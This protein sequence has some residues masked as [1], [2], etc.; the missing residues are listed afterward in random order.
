MN[1]RLDPAI[2]YKDLPPLRRTGVSYYLGHIT[3]WVKFHT[4]RYTPDDYLND[5][6]DDYLGVE[7]EELGPECEEL[8]DALAEEMLKEMDQEISNSLMGAQNESS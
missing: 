6:L 3:R 8:V 7:Y 2:T 4:G 5:F 1:K